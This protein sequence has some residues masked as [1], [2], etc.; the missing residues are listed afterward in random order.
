MDLVLPPEPVCLT[1]L[2][3]S[4]GD[5]GRGGRMSLILPRG[6]TPHGAKQAG[7]GLEASLLVQVRR[8]CFRQRNC[9]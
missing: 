5:P 7:E 9:A 6:S 8:L 4:L 3:W 1:R 2:L